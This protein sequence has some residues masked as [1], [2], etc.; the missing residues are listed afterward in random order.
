MNMSPEPLPPAEAATAVPPECD[1]ARLAYS[2]YV[3]EG[4]PEG[5][6][7]EHWVRAEQNLRGIPPWTPE[8]GAGDA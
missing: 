5:F 2:Y 1:I 4:C 7:Q 3:E 8:N 6:A